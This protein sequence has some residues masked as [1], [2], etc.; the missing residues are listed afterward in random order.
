[1]QAPL[2]LALA[3]SIALPSLAS[4]RPAQ[5]AAPQQESGGTFTNAKMG[6]KLKPPKG[7]EMVALKTDE[8]WLSCK[9]RSDKSYAYHDKDRGYTTRHT[10]ELKVI[11]FVKE[12]MDDEAEITRDEDEDGNKRITITTKN[13]Y[14]DYDDYL[15]RTVSGGFFKDDEDRTEIDGRQ[16]DIYTYRLEKLSS[17][18]RFIRTWIYRTDEIDYAVQ[19]EVLQT[20]D[21]GLKRTL[22]RTFKSFEVTERSGEDLADRGGWITRIQMN[23]GTPK[24]RREKRMESEQLMRQRAMDSVPDSWT[25]KEYG[26]FLILS[27]TDKRYTKKIA[28]HVQAMH[29]WLEDTFPYVGEGEYVRAPIVRILANDEQWRAFTQG[30]GD[31]F[32][33]GYLGNGLEVYTAKTS[34]GYIGYAVDNLNTSMFRMWF[35]ERDSDMFDAMPPWLQ[36]GLEWVIE[37]AR[38]DGRKLKFRNDRDVIDARTYIAQDKGITPLDIL[39]LTTKDMRVSS[40][41]EAI[42]RDVKNMQAYSFCRYVASSDARKNKYAKNFLETYLTTLKQVVKEIEEKD[43]DRYKDIGKPE[44]EEEEDAWARARADRRKQQEN[45]IIDMV[46]ERAFGDWDDK[47]WESLDKAWKAWL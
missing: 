42:V 46:L 14:K 21:K 2:T 23:E 9:Y 27:D 12:N 28:D 36:F 26:D 31:R 29:K 13:P 39:R 47:A 45:E 4:A 10:P 7:W 34:T 24:E 6:F 30:S 38:A 19:M 1:M 8:S 16:V 25:T 11:S 44:T 32:R 37:S 5:P 3:L 15:E 41:A 43:K 40:Q 17:A 35:R 33:D 20:E 18:P 22:E